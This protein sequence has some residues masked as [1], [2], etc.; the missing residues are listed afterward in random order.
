MI[1]ALLFLGYLAIAGVCFGASARKMHKHDPWLTPGPLCIAIFW[2]L[3][4]PFYL[5]ARFAGMFSDIGYSITDYAIERDLRIQ[6]KK[7]QR[8]RELVER[9]REIDRITE[10]L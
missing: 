6:E 1:S 7:A 3:V 5:T 10:A 4:L 8:E 2:P 9:Q